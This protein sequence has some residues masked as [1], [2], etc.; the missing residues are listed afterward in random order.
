[1]SIR[2][3]GPFWVGLAA[4]LWATDALVRFPTIASVD[5]TFIV[6]FEHVLAVVLLFPWIYKNHK[7]LMFRLNGAEWFSA[8][9]SG[10]AGSAFA[11]LFFTASF[12]YLNP[13]VAVLLQKLQPV[14]VMLIAWIFLKETP[15]PKFFL[16][17]SI[18]IASA[19]LLSFP[20][21]QFPFITQDFSF[22][23]TGVQYAL[24]AAL[25]WAGSTVTGK[26]L[27]IR[28]PPLL[29]TFWRFFFG[30]LGLSAFL[31]VSKTTLHW[32]IL[33]PSPLLYSLIYLSLIPGLFAM[34]IYYY[35]LASTPASVTSFIE[36]IYP[37]G[38]ILLN[39]LY[40][41]TPLNTVQTLSGAILLV[42][43]GL[44]SRF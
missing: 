8:L 37:I 36:L 32:E 34:L 22:D 13:S 41:H 2:L 1:M 33:T 16:L 26:K 43:V 44:M 14:L 4:F 40:L 31:L 28:T 17:G 11:T 20:D 23:F 39:T 25:L 18:A 29:A 5:P 3:P 15:N 21:F 27:L 12:Q 6:F 42:A 30:F 9:F 35:G 38:A 19:I 7:D 10:L 24:G